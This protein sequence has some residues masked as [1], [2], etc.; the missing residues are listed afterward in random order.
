MHLEITV[1]GPV[2]MNHEKQSIPIII[3]H[4]SKY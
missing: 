3:T 1:T 4:N 2:T